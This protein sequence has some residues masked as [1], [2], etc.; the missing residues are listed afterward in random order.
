VEVLFASGRP[1][2]L[3]EFAIDP[4]R[5][6]NPV[7]M[8][9]ARVPPRNSLA[10]TVAMVEEK[11]RASPA[12]PHYRQILPNDELLIP[13]VAFRV[14]HHFRELEGGDKP[15][16][17]AAMEGRWIAEALQSV[18]FRLDRSGAMLQSESRMAVP[19]TLMAPSWS[20]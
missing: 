5:T 16:L 12:D 18:R 9:L 4:C 20:I 11:I 3:T 8:V 17:N 1:I 19:S 14:L 7:Q 10:D 15:F 13:N 2:D 6:S